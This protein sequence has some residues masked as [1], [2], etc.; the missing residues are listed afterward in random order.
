MLTREKNICMYNL[1]LQGK[2]TIA[3]YRIRCGRAQ[4]DSLCTGDPKNPVKSWRPGPHCGVSCPFQE[5]K[6]SVGKAE[7][8]TLEA[9][10]WRQRQALEFLQRDRSKPFFSFPFYSTQAV[11]LLVGHSHPYAT[12]NYA[13]PII[14]TAFLAQVDTIVNYRKHYNICTVRS[15]MPKIKTDIL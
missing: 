2:F 6:G 9:R 13:K 8:S 15:Q 4:K 5:S 7:K 3:T 14:K 10:K 11:S 1:A 12:Q